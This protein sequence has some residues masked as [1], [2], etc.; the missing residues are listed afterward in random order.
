MKFSASDIQFAQKINFELVA[1]YF[2]ALG[3][4]HEIIL[5]PPPTP[6]SA[7]LQAKILS[8]GNWGYGFLKTDFINF[9]ERF[10]YLFL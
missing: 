1:K 8:D 10:P 9:R 4:N 2:N 3:E 7:T 5:P 6:I